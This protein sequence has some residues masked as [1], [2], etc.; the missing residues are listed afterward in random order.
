MGQL[1]EV[2]DL[3]VESANVLLDDVG[4][5]LDLHRMVIVETATCSHWEGSGQ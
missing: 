1:L 5:L 3:S 2:G 4:E